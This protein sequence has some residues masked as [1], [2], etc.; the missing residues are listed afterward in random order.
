MRTLLIFTAILFCLG[1]QSDSTEP[2]DIPLSSSPSA[3][4]FQLL[5]ADQSGIS[6]SNEIQETFTTNL[7]NLAYIYNGSGVCVLDFDQDGWQDLLF[8]GSQT[9]THLYRNKGGMQFEEVSTS[10][11]VVPPPGF[12]T[13]ASIVDINT[14]GYPDIYICRSGIDNSDAGKAIRQNLLYIN[15]GDG[16]FSE[17]AAAYGLNSNR[18]ATQAYWLDYDLDGDLDCYL[19][20]TPNDFLTTTRVRVSAHPTLGYERVTTPIEIWESDQLLRNDNGRFTDVSTQAGI[21]NRAFGLS[22]IIMDINEDGRPDIYVC[23]DYIEPD[24][25]YINLGNGTFSDQINNYF[26][27]TCANT[28]GS[29]IGDINNDGL[30]DIVSL[31][32]LAEDL[33]RRKALESSM[34]RDR[35]E[36]LVRLGYGY[37]YMKNTL[38]LNVGNGVYSEI[39]QLAG[40]GAT[41]WSWAALFADFDNDRFNDLYVTNGYRYDISNIDYVSF[42]A[43]SIN[44]LGGISPQRFPDFEDYLKLIPSEPL[45]NYMYRNNGRLQFDNVAT[46]WGLDHAGFSTSTAYADFD[47]DGDLDLAVNNIEMPAFIYENQAAQRND[48]HYLRVK[49]AGPGNNP[50]GIGMEARIF[51]GNEQQVKTLFTTR[52][53]LGAVEPVLHFGLGSVGAID[54][55]EIRWPDGRQQTINRPDLDQE[56]T[57][58]YND[59]GRARANEDADVATI[60]NIPTDQLG[61]AFNHGENE[62]NDFDRE[63]LLPYKLSQEGPALCVADFNGD[64]NEDVFLGSGSGSP[65]QLF[66]GTP[67]GRFQNT[68]IGEITNHSN[69]ED[70]AAIALDADADGDQDLYVVS[71]GSAITQGN[72][73]L[74]DRLYLNDGNARFAYAPNWLPDLRFSGGAVVTTDLNQDQLPDLIVAGRHVPGRFPSAPPTKVLLNTGNNFR[75]ATAEVSPDLAS[76]G[77]VTELSA[78]DLNG[79]GVDEILI[80]GDFLP[81]TIL[82]NENG[83]LRPTNNFGTFP[84]GFWNELHLFDADG[85]GDLDLLAGNEGLNS[86][87]RTSE[88]EPLTLVATDLDGNGS[89]DPILACYNDGELCPFVRRD[90]LVLQLPYLREQF[91]RNNRYAAARLSDF[92]S[93]EVMATAPTY[94]VQRLATTFY[95]NENGRFVQSEL[96][97]EA[98]FAPVNAAISDDFNQDGFQDLILVG[99][100]YGPEVETGRYDASN[101]T[102]LEGDGNGNFSFVPN[103][104]TGFWTSLNARELAKVQFANGS[105]AIVVGNNSAPSRVFIQE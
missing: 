11:G 34:V 5:T 72:N 22:A 28:M 80:A 81:I 54:R 58:N 12:N 27:H 2:I 36:T 70:V 7:I 50:R 4:G 97:V 75:D 18:P 91:L 45:V 101:G 93:P 14:D 10:A 66:L 62:F 67:A 26:R 68:A 61:L 8:V 29:D 52:G 92:I 69:L 55:L 48:N 46:Q 35:F 71:G 102:F 78:T 95:R 21:N 15:H 90:N 89:I 41:D 99:N 42:T 16:T 100:D 76:I 82:Q 31:D 56:L 51:Y 63:R 74:Q 43:D 85:D 20:N 64:G 94:T 53:F 9:N 98:Q 13:G 65:S 23:N 40:V 37:Q 17:Q 25:L 39:G 59:A 47:K 6:F 57:I 73:G 79:D 32:M 87:F 104:E 96:P 30:A 24:F 19:V 49:A 103:R 84:T 86:R 33:V 77:M 88:Q 1:C 60:F 44:R 83:I 105:Q 38:Q 3:A